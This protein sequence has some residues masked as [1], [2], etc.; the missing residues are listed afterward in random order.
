MRHE[1]PVS[2]ED[3]WI[4]AKLQGAPRFLPPQCHELLTIF[5]RLILNSPNGYGGW[6]MNWATIR[7]PKHARWFLERAASSALWSRKLPIH[8]SRKLFRLLRTLQSSKI[9]STCYPHPSLIKMV[10]GKQCNTWR[11]YD[12]PGSRSLPHRYI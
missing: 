10:S 4:S 7:T 9:M 1:S 11:L 8:Y 5:P 12:I 3:V 6:S 2:A